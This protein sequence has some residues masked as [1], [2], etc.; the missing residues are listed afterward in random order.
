MATGV[1]SLPAGGYWSNAARTNANIQQAGEDIISYARSLFGGST[2]TTVTLVTGVASPAIEVGTLE[3]V[4]QVGGVADDLVTITTTNLDDGSV[5]LILPKNPA[6]E[7]I[8]IK[9][10]GNIDTLDGAEVILQTTDAALTADGMILQRDGANWVERSRILE[11]KPIAHRALLGLG[12]AAVLNT[13]TGVSDLPDT[14]DIL[15]KQSIYVPVSSMY[16]PAAAGRQTA[17]GLTVVDPD[18]ADSPSRRARSFDP[19]TIESMEFDLAMPKSWDAGNIQFVAHYYHE[20][21]QAGGKD[22]VKWGMRAVCRSDGDAIAQDYGT[23]EG[24]V[25]VG[26]TADTIYHSTEDE[27]T[28]GGT[29]AKGDVM[30]VQI[31]RLHSGVTNDMNIDVSLLGVLLTYTIDALNDD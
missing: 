14:A 28:A 29:P 12:T 18:D 5:I 22:D 31:S 23:E 10:T 21:G 8:T 4:S 26:A 15:G 6:T 19:T 17:G 13:G 27:F 30:Y 16:E 7:P 2:P 11:N 24:V 1:P 9:S 25:S 3:I 20:G